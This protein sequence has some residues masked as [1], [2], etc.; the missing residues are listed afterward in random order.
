MIIANG[1]HKEEIKK[2]GIEN[3]SKKYEALVN[4]IQS[5]LKW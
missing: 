2:D 5:D 1:I 3:V 4:Y